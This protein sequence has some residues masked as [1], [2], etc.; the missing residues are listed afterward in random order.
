[1]YTIV[2]KILGMTSI[3][4]LSHYNGICGAEAFSHYAVLCVVFLD[5]MHCIVT[6]TD[7]RTTSSAVLGCISPKLS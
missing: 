5:Y 3:R 7:V 2:D 1:M 4:S 6:D